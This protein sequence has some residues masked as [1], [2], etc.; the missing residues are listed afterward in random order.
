MSVY[1]GPNIGTDDLALCL[2][3]ANP[4]SNPGSGTTWFDI[5]GNDRNASLDDGAYFAGNDV[6]F[7][8]VDDGV[9]LGRSYFETV[10]AFS[11]VAW[12]RPDGIKGGAQMIVY[13][14]QGDGFGGNNEFHLH[15]DAGAVQVA[16]YMQGGISLGS[17]AGSIDVSQFNQAAYT[18]TGLDAT[19]TG[20]L[21]LNG[22]FEAT[23]TGT[24]SRTGYG[25]NTLVG[26]PYSLAFPTPPRSFAGVIQMV[27]IYDRALTA[28]EIQQNFRALRGRFGI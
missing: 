16:A 18:V 8:G 23:G 4:E 12:F 21:Y 11:V 15:Y 19:A 10:D 24:I 2:D 26:R 20:T 5:S 1:S 27:M 7:D 13:E 9:D 28:V 25:V 17:G 3:A 22:E 6:V 14:G